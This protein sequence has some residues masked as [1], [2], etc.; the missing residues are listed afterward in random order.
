MPQTFE[1]IKSV[2]DGQIITMQRCSCW[3][4]GNRVDNGFV[5]IRHPYPHHSTC[6]ESKKELVREKWR[7]TKEQLHALRAE[8]NDIR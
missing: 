4:L 5:D 8:L 3:T 7:T 6:A 1:T 2:R